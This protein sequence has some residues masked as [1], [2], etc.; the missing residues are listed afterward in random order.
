MAFAKGWYPA[1]G[2]IGEQYPNEVR[3]LD[4]QPFFWEF[5]QRYYVLLIVLLLICAVFCLYLLRKPRS[6]TKTFENIL[7]NICL[8]VCVVLSILIFSVFLDKFHLVSI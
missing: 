1:G 8:S 4:W 5:T 2:S 6:E 7:L 3:E